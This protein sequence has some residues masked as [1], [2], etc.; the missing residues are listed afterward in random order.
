MKNEKTVFN[1]FVGC[2]F[3]GC[4]KFS[5]PLRSRDG[6]AFPNKHTAPFS[7]AGQDS[8]RLD[9]LINRPRQ[10]SSCAVTHGGYRDGRLR[11]VYGYYMHTKYT[12]QQKKGGSFKKI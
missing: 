8:L 5:A 10:S 12:C 11:V 7:S 9:N 3:V 1:H 2:D 6:A 4:D